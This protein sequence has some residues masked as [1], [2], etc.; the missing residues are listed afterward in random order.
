MPKISEIAKI[1][2][3][4]KGVTPQLKAISRDP[5]LQR[6]HNGYYRQVPL[7]F[8]MNPVRRFPQVWLG[9]PPY[10]YPAQRPVKFFLPDLEGKPWWDRDSNSETLENNVDD[11]RKEFDEVCDRVKKHPQKYL[12]DKGNWSTFFLYR[13]GKVEEN[14]RACPRTTQI[15]ESLP[16]CYK[17]KS[18]VYFSVMMPGTEIKPHCGPVNTRLR[19]HLPIAIDDKA[20]MRVDE[21]KRSWKSGECFV[22]DDS[23]EHEVQHHGSLPR[24]VL[25]VDCWHPALSAPERRCLEQLYADL[26]VM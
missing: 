25:L 20:W 4:L 9:R 12:V 22:F 24:V 3:R 18:A 19:Y 21:E 14:C 11:I 7:S 15:V 26:S 5:E 10:R 23:F 16:L 6:I 2:K 17:V 13:S 8:A 1:Y